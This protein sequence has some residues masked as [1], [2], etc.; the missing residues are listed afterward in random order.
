M[1]VRAVRQGV[2]LRMASYLTIYCGR[3]H[4]TADGF[5]IGHTCRVLAPE[6][7]AAERAKDYEL[8]LAILERMPLTLREGLPDE[9]SATGP[10][11]GQGPGEASRSDPA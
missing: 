1:A 4:R 2:S 7:L 8:A 3:P 5:P 9:S 11:E 10:C 6:Y